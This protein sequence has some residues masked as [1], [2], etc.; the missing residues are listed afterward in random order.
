MFLC[1]IELS[2]L[3][4]SL[5]FNAARMITPTLTSGHVKSARYMY[6]LDVNEEIDDVKDLSCV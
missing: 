3:V 1:A 4:W 6:C 5:F 2:S